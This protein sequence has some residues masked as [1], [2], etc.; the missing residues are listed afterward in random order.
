MCDVKRHVK[1]RGV[2]E[3]HTFGV[4]KRENVLKK[5][6]KPPLRNCIV[7]KGD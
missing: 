1:P 3:L 2:L 4:E 5:D 7:T 6:E